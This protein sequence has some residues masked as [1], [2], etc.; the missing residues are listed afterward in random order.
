MLQ[1]TASYFLIGGSTGC[2]SAQVSVSAANG[3]ALAAALN[4]QVAI[5]RLP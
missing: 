1:G 5:F 3:T 2:A 4:A